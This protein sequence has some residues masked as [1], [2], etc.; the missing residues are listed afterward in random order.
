[1]IMASHR[2][3]DGD[4]PGRMGTGPRRT[5]LPAGHRAPRGHPLRGLTASSA[6]SFLRGYFGNDIN[7]AY[8]SVF[9][10]I[11]FFRDTGQYQALCFPPR[12]NGSLDHGAPHHRGT[13]PWRPSVHVPGNSVKRPSRVGGNRLGDHPSRC[14]ASRLP[15]HP[16]LGYPRHDARD[17]RD[18]GRG[19]AHRELNGSP[20]QSSI[21]GYTMTSKILNDI[22][23]WIIVPEPQGSPLR[24]RARPL[25][26]GGRDGGASAGSICTPGWEVTWG[27][28]GVTGQ[29][30]R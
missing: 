21:P 28:E 25:P 18:H 20:F 1:M 6:F 14:G 7:P 23:Y 26:H 24:H 15:R 4:L 9:G 30:R 5:A 17:G 12:C 11:P 8:R 27:G 2:R 10:W 19:H 3:P 16:D 29:R 13:S 22:G